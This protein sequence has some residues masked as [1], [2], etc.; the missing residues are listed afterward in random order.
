M[1]SPNYADLHVNRL[2]TSL[3]VAYIQTDDKFVGT[4]VFP[5]VPN[6][7]KSD[8]FAQYDR[9]DFMRD[10]MQIRG[11]GAESAGGGYRVTTND[12]FSCDVW[13]FHVDTDYQTDA[14]TD[15]PFNNDN[16]AAIYL[17]QKDLIRKEVAWGANYF[18]TGVWTGGL[19]ASGSNGDLVAN[20]D[21]TPWDDVASTPIEDVDAQKAEIESNTGHMPNTLVL[22]RRGWFALKNHPDIVDRIKH[23]SRDS[24]TTAMVANL[25]EI[26]RILVS[27]G[28]SNS[29]QEG[30]TAVTDY[31]MGKHALLV[32]SAPNPG[33]Y[34]V[35]GGYTFVWSQLNGGASMDG[36]SVSTI[37][38]D[39]KKV[40]RHEI[41]SAWAMKVVAPLCGA[42]FQN[43]VS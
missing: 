40:N 1:P 41:E 18:T 8:R 31:I 5:I 21:F 19:K 4:K 25:M 37:P 24:V 39:W 42:F 29:A 35:S 3:S 26:D 13:S 36:V 6:D 38:M 34:V 9:G 2:M 15:A 7:R 22:N 17:G 27:G 30:V 16:D 11:P 20:T 43:V 14:N 10:E 32:Y 23:V 28:A 12:T 33:R